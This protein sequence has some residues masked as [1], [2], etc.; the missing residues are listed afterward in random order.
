[1]RRAMHLAI[2]RHVLVDVVKD[3]APMQIGG[4]V[5]PVP[6]VVTPRRRSWRS[7]SATRRTRRRPIQEAKKLMQAAGYGQGLKNLDFVVR[8]IASFKLWAVAIQAMLKENLNIETNLRV[9][10]ISQWFEEAAAGNFDLGDQRDRVLADGPVRL[11]HRLVRQ[12]RPAEL[13]GLDQRA[14]PLPRP[15]TSSARWTRTSARR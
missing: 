12:G 8:D 4:F 10:Q 11:L 14:I 1:M 2:D 6:R 5:Y 15:A 9:V 3:T 13:L 7:G